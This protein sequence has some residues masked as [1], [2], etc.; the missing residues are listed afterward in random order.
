MSNGQTVRD[1][2]EALFSQEAQKN[3]R[4]PKCPHTS[5]GYNLQFPFYV[6][7]GNY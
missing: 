5:L 6:L 2:T 1:I 3:G 7:P 4:N